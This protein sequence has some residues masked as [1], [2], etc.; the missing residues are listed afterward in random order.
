MA[1]HCNEE[2]LY[3]LVCGPPVHP[4]SVASPFRSIPTASRKPETAC[5]WLSTLNGP[6]GPRRFADASFEPGGQIVEMNGPAAIDG[7][8]IGIP[9]L[10]FADARVDEMETCAIVF[11]CQFKGDRGGARLKG[12]P[13]IAQAKSGAKIISLYRLC[14]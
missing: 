1:R 10:P 7:G 13:G 2:S 14:F 12:F 11:R 5:N 3:V 8:V 9:V 6:S 4:F